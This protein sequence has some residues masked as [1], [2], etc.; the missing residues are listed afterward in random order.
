M[1]RNNPVLLYGRNSILERMRANPKSLR[2]VMISENFDDA[3][4]FE[5]AK[6]HRTPIKRVAEKELFKMKHSERLQGII[7]EADPFEYS[8]FEG[9]LKREDGIKPTFIM[10][11]G[12]T[13]PQNLGAIIRT[14]ACF[15]SFAIVIPERD[16]CD[17][18]ETVLNVASGGENYVRVCRINNL[19]NA[20]IHAKEAGYW[21][22]GA[23]VGGGEDLNKAS[24]PFPLC[25][26]LG[27]EGKGIHHGVSKHIEL[28]VTLP[29]PGAALS[30]NVAISAAIFCYEIARQREAGKKQK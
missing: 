3:E 10:L 29:M 4:I 27:S 25:L 2:M 16:S 30:F 23:V 5:A 6:L 20:L 28:K 19:S 8:S 24:F 21:A 1:G 7:A 14:S 12:I 18:N 15:G 22:A 17:V 13:D 26:V 9:L 11:D